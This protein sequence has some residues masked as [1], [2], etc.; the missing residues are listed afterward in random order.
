MPSDLRAE[1]RRGWRADCKNL[2][3]RISF[4]TWTPKY[5]DNVKRALR[6]MRERGAK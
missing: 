5:F 2:S 4:R 3:M 6:N 1:M